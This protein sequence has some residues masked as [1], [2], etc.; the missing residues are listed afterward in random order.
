MRFGGEALL[1]LFLGHNSEVVGA[2]ALR[3]MELFSLTYLTC[4]FNVAISAFFT[5]VNRP[6]ASLILSFG[7]A[8]V[9]PLLALAVLPRLWG[10]DGVWLTPACGSGAA[11]VFLAAKRTEDGT[12]G[13]LRRELRLGN[14]ACPW[15]NRGRT[16]GSCVK[17][18][19]ADDGRKIHCA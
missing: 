5:A 17:R 18:G 12:G 7:N 14:C 10:I 1:S 15:Y 8:L 16:D 2:L 4:W 9:F 13:S 19:L 6:G 11:A 3:A